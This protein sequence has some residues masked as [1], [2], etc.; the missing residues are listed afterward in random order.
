VLPLVAVV[1][2]IGSPLQPMQTRAYALGSPDAEQAATFVRG[3][4]ACEGPIRV[5]SAVGGVD[6]WANGAERPGA[7]SVRDAITGRI[8]AIGE[9][10]IPPRPPPHSI[11]VR[12]SVPAISRVRVCVTERGPYRPRCSGRFRPT[13]RFG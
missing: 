8:L 2:L 3:Q 4:E 6:I 11:P 5:P 10:T 12:P 9:T 13:R 1:A 7:V